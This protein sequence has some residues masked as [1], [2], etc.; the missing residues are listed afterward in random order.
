MVVKFYDSVAL[1]SGVIIDNGIYA[2]MVSVDIKL[3]IRLLLP[4]LALIRPCAGGKKAEQKIISV[5][6]EFVFSANGLF[7]L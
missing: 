5:T 4:P 1:W 3:T 7:Q 2:P 6:A